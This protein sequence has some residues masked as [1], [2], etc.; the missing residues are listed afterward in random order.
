MY[1]IFVMQIYR[2]STLHSHLRHTSGRSQPPGNGIGGCEPRAAMHYALPELKSK[3]SIRLYRAVYSISHKLPSFLRLQALH[4]SFAWLM[5]G[6]GA[7]RVSTVLSGRL[8]R[9]GI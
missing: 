1:V 4:I 9:F 8:R 6:C 3:I 7:H 2:P 5:R